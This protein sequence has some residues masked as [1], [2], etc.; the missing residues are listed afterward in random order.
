MTAG[1]IDFG[2]VGFVLAAWMFAELPAATRRSRRTVVWLVSY[3]AFPG[4]GALVC[5]VPSTA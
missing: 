1:L 5:C 3:C 4:F 2:V